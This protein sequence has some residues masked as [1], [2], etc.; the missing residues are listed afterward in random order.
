MA[1]G[2]KGRAVRISEKTEAALRKFRKPDE[3]WSAAIDRVTGLAERHVLCIKSS[4]GDS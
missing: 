3:P 4:K 2:K 1:K